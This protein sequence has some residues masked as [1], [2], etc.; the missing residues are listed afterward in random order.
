MC[1]VE[2]LSLPISDSKV[3]K[4]ER[5]LCMYPR[6]GGWSKISIIDMRHKLHVK[7]RGDA[8]IINNP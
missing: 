8:T 5:I 2:P 1:F 7:S 4:Q 6:P 3:S